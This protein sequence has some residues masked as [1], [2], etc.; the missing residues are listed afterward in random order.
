MLDT[1]WGLRFLLTGF[2][3]WTLVVADLKTSIPGEPRRHDIALDELA[4][5]T[6][7]HHVCDSLFHEAVTVP[8]PRS[9]RNKFYLL[10][11]SERFWRAT[12]D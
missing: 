8:H 12:W 9:G 3:M 2:S 4:S 7:Q 5:E 1:G 11:G 10:V 6:R